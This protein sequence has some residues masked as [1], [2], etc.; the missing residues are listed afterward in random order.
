[1]EVSRAKWF[2]LNKDG[3]PTNYEQFLKLAEAQV[4]KL[5]LSSWKD[6]Y[7]IEKVEPI[8]EEPQFNRFVSI[9]KQIKGKYAPVMTLHA[10]TSPQKVASISKHGFLMPGDRI[11]GTSKIVCQS[12]GALL[13]SGLYTS[14]SFDKASWYGFKDYN[15]KLYILVNMVTLGNLI[16]LDKKTKN[17]M[18]YPFKSVAKRAKQKLKQPKILHNVGL[19]VPLNGTYEHTYHTLALCDMSQVVSASTE[20]VLPIFKI[21]LRG[22]IDTAVSKPQLSF[23]GPSS[24]NSW[25]IDLD[26]KF[27]FTEQ[28]LKNRVTFNRITK[29][30]YTVKPPVIEYAKSTPEI[31]HTLIVPLSEN[32][33]FHTGLTNFIDVISS[34]HKGV[35]LY[36]NSGLTPVFTK[37]KDGNHLNSILSSSKRD[38][39][40][41]IT[42]ALDNVLGT[43]MI[44]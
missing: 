10:T 29:D 40:C 9:H 11:P 16:F 8:V 35:V 19:R 37:L 36:G 27:K 32:H 26:R 38:T 5:D 28:E 18:A 20:Y 2:Q 39:N 31:R 7:E 14:T 43:L 41:S 30:L 25:L 23:R 44:L 21:T 33:E 17:R 15:G 13:G 6:T 1:M 22:R 4:G 12:Y 34:N 24:N 42:K 3:T